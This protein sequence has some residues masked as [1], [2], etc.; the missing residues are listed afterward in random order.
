MIQKLDRENEVLSKTIDWMRFPLAF[1]I[2]LRHADLQNEYVNGQ[3]ILSNIDAPVYD[4]L[5]AI[6]HTF[7]GIAVPMFFLFSGYLFF[8]KTRSMSDYLPQLRKRVKSL[9]MPYLFWNLVYILIRLSSQ[10]LMPSLLSGRNKPIMEYSF[11]EYLS[12]FWSMSFDAGGE[13]PI[14]GPLWFVR[15]MMVLMILFPIIYFILKHIKSAVLPL[16]AVVFI[17]DFWWNFTGLSTSALCFFSIGAFFGMYR[18]NF[19]SPLNRFSIPLLICYVATLVADYIFNSELSERVC[20]MTGVLTAISIVANYIGRRDVKINK[21]LAGCSFFIFAF[22]YDVLKLAIKLLYK[23]FEPATDSGV[24]TLYIAAPTIV[25]GFGLLIYFV[26]ARFTP[27][28]FKTLAT[29]GR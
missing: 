13:H 24:I 18:K 15:D 1:L 11:G 27:S 19:T 25:A 6:L 21:W 29:G 10:I 26:I 2:V 17:G 22:H 3:S 12:C 14:D 7:T 28:F 23:L 5:F 4:F 20:V 8:L 16:L 9:L